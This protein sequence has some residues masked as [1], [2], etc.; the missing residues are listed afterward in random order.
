[1][2]ADT[3]TSFTNLIYNKFSL[4]LSSKISELYIGYSPELPIILI[5]YNQMSCLLESR[6]IIVNS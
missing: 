6:L 5:L 2:A 4:Y 3:W 1:M